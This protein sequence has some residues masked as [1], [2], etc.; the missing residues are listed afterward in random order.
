[1]LKFVK[2]KKAAIADC[3]LK[4]ILTPMKTWSNIVI[5]SIPTK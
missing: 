3:P 4:Q 1:M 2:N 5:N